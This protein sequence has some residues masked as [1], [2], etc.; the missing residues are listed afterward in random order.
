MIPRAVVR[1]SSPLAAVS[2]F[3]ARAAS[4]D[5]TYALRYFSDKKSDDSSSKDLKLI[6]ACLDA[7]MK[8]EGPIPDEEK[9]RRY[10][11]GRDHVI[12]RFKQHNE[13]AH[14]LTCKMRLKAHAINMLP[15]NTKLREQALKISD[16]MPPKWRNIPVWTPP[17]EGFD[18]EEYNKGEST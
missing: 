2:L 14:D 11:I 1:S 8:K 6:M 18:P 12:G 15:K 10:K 3:R 5:A 7:P 17:I 13:M 16:E 4:A 9:E